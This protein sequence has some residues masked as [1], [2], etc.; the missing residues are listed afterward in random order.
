MAKTWLLAKAMIKNSLGLSL[1]SK[2]GRRALALYIVA[3][4]FCLV[5]GAMLAFACFAMFA[6]GFLEETVGM[7]L[8]LENAL[9]ILMAIFTI[10][11]VFYFSKDLMVYLAMPLKPSQIIAAK[12]ILLAIYLAPVVLIGTIVLVAGA[13]IAGVFSAAQIFLMFLGSVLS[14]SATILILCSLM[15]I[16]MR[17]MPFF[18]NKDR[19]MV[20]VGTFSIFLA[21]GSVYLSNTVADASI[22]ADGLPVMDLSD[23]MWIFPACL[24]AVKS[25]FPP[26]LLWA[27]AEIVFVALCGALFYWVSSTMYLNTAMDAISAAPKKVKARKERLA[28]NSLDQMLFKMDLRRLLRTPAYLTNNVLA[29]LVMPLLILVSFGSGLAKS[30]NPEEVLNALEMYLDGAG[31]SRFWISVLA[32]L[33]IGY[34]FSCMN[35]IC[36]TAIS[37]EGRDGVAWMKSVPISFQRQLIAKLN[38]GMLFSVASGLIVIVIAAWFL[39]WRLIFLA[40]SI[41]GLVAGALLDNLSAL[42][43]DIIHPK[44]DWQE[45]AAA[46]KNNFNVFLDMIVPFVLMAIV[47]GLIVMGCPINILTMVLFAITIIADGLMWR[48]LGKFFIRFQQ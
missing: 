15:M 24:F 21:V 20:I 36:G 3:F 22:G 33:M 13:L 31:I 44:L 27:A 18:R 28:H 38:V 10:P 17:L 32:G 4:V 34:L 47:F 37:R 35:S 9:L 11:S 46:A 5:Y 8:F 40:G 41:L 45:E 42:L 12:T 2:K 43:V 30:G 23:K 26:N 25:I 39:P 1:S 6:T 29:S 16:L 48:L 7:V 14:M 19:F